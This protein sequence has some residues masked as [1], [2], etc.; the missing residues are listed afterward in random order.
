MLLGNHQELVHMYV[1]V[2]SDLSQLHALAMPAI[3]YLKMCTR[4]GKH[5]IKVE[6]RSGENGPISRR[7]DIAA[8]KDRERDVEP[9]FS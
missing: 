1:L 9:T 5:L 2:A 7:D 6:P 8:Y 4:D 3:H